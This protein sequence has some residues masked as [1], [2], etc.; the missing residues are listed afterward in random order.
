MFPPLGPRDASQGVQPLDA[1]G[2]QLPTVE[3]APAEE[4]EHFHDMP[5]MSEARTSADVPVPEDVDLDDMIE[6]LP[7]ELF[8]RPL[9]EV[10]GASGASSSTSRPRL[11]P[12]PTFEA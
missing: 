3:E 4:V 7:D 5:P 8:K 10:P 1:D 11:E 9:E 6:R 2:S 12:P